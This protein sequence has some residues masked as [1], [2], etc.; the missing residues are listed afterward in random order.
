MFLTGWAYRRRIDIQTAYLDANLADFPLY[1]KIDADGH[2]G[3]KARSDGYDI[4]F[5]TND[6]VT[7]LK[8]ERESWAVSDGKATADFWVKT[9]LA[10]A[11]TYIYVYYGKADAADGADP[12]N[13]WDSDFKAVYHMSDYDASH[14]HDSTANVNHGTK[15]AANEP[16]QAAGRIGY[17]QDF[18]AL[19]DYIAVPDSDTL[20]FPNLGLGNLTVECY[21][22]RGVNVAG[23]KRFLDKRFTT[24]P[25]SGWCFTVFNSGGQ[26]L[27][28]TCGPTLVVYTGYYFT[29]DNWHHI[30]VSF[31]R[32]GYGTTYVDGVP[33]DYENISGGAAQDW[34]SAEQFIMGSC[35][36]L[37]YSDATLDEVRISQALRTAAWV[38]FEYRNMAEADNELTWGAQELAP[39]YA[40]LIASPAAQR[41]FLVRI[42]PREQLRG[43][44]K[45]AG[46]TYTYEISWAALSTMGDFG[47]TWRALQGVE[48]NGAA[49]TARASIALVDANAGSYYFDEATSK[50]YV[51]CTDDGAADRE[52]VY[53]VA[54]FRLHFASGVGRNGKGKIFDGIYY[55][56]LF[57]K[58]SLPA[59]Q[60]EQTDFLT[61]GGMASGDLTVEL[62]NCKRFFDKVWTAWSWKNAPVEVLH[63]G[64]ALPLTEYALVYTGYVKDERWLRDRVSFDT[65]NYLELLTRQVPVSPLFGASVL[66]ADRGKP[67]PLCFGRVS[68]IRPLCSNTSPANGTEWT[69]ADAAFQ[70]LYAIPAVYDAGADVTAFVTK[71]LANCKFTF[72]NYTPTG[73]VSCDVE[74]AK[75]SDIPGESDTSLMTNAAD[76]VRFFLLK[77]LGLDSTQINTAAFTAAKAALAD[78][79][80]CRYVRNRRNLSSYINEVERSVLGIVYQENDGRLSFDAFNPLYS[81]DA[82]IEDQEIA[83]YEQSAPSDKIFAGVQVYYDPRPFPQE[84]GVLD[85]EG[86]EDSYEVLAG[87]NA[88]ARYVD[89]QETAYRRVYSWLKSEACAEVLKQRLLFLTNV[90]VLQLSLTVN[91]PK[92]YDRKPGDILKV[93]KAIAATPSGSLADLYF[94]VIGLSKE[95][96]AGRVAVVI[97]NFQGLAGTVGIWSSDAA[98]A[99][100]SAT[101]EQKDTQGF[102]S[103]EEGNVVAGDW[104]TNKQSVWW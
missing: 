88:R 24:A 19:D 33:V 71:D 57:L 96:G 100:A 78:S 45:T 65:V 99:W 76:I 83:G 90:P 62:A 81:A 23:W 44:T 75:I 6:G 26:Q 28:Y 54:F 3:A 22:K 1:V 47:T 86:G 50:I 58:D 67:I 13:V 66:E 60:S 29:D 102:W 18:D 64:E 49:L 51:R 61:G 25:F 20:D 14:I 31:D 32:S 101:Q 21:Y 59:I 41:D 53:I 63:G 69:I 70:T 56:P 30:V 52:S 11:G 36:G 97:D 89:K 73:E 27:V 17:G 94:Q 2:I 34:R 16:V 7:L 4:R 93:N 91:G 104:T 40:N 48:Q 92:L 46:Y 9:S 39:T 79:E 87:T 5:A 72:S 85:S 38:K 82:T 15:K 37:E 8:Y 80:L 35:Y 43:W 68:G 103:D 77:V 95:L 42:T 55:E 84:G 98:P 10:M 12:A 74:G